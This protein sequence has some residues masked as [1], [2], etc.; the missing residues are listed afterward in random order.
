[1]KFLMEH[2]K[3][4]IL[5]RG[6]H[7]DK[8]CELCHEDQKQMIGFSIKHTMQGLGI[9]TSYRE[10]EREKMYIIYIFPSHHQ[11][12]IYEFH[13]FENYCYKNLKLRILRRRI[14]RCMWWSFVFWWF[15]S[16]Y[17][18]MG[19]SLIEKLFGSWVSL[20]QC[21]RSK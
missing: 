20:Q 11:T 21:H 7:I 14:Q 12:T 6:S 2:I 19:A 3:F 4:K 17:L 18:K 9:P 15:L 8:C 1:M 10:I 5:L 13:R 16:L